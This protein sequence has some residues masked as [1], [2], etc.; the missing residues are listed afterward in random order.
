MRNPHVG[1]PQSACGI[2]RISS[3][4]DA[5]Q[6][7]RRQ[8]H[9]PRNGNWPQITLTSLASFAEVKGQIW[10]N[11]QNC[12]AMRSFLH[13][14]LLSIFFSLVIFS[15]SNSP[16]NYS[17]HILSTTAFNCFFSVRLRFSLINAD[18]LVVPDTL[19]VLIHTLNTCYNR[20]YLEF[21]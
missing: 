11:T 3:D 2:P 18:C 4:Y 15:L 7:D 5:A 21:A 13:V 16:L 6:P 9:R 20:V 12:Y 17:A 1:D 8:T 14:F 10:A 19:I